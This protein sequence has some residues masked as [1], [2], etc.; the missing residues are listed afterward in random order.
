MDSA[1]EESRCT[2]QVVS[3]PDGIVSLAVIE[4]EHIL[5]VFRYCG[6]NLARTARILDISRSTIN[7]KLKQ[8]FPYV[9]PHELRDVILGKVG[10]TNVVRTLQETDTITP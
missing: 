9:A 6:G 3:L 10:E 7:N 1:D 8:Y 2:V 5:R 4:R